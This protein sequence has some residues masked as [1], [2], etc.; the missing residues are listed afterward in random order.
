MTAEVGG[1]RANVRLAGYT[2]PEHDGGRIHGRG[3]LEWEG[4][5]LMS[6]WQDTHHHNM[7][8]VGFMVEDC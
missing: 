7:L 2:P 6:G 5:G 8:V 3:L 1:G 4:E